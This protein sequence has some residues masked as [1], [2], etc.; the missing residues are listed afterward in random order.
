MPSEGA[1]L[2]RSRQPASGSRPAGSRSQVP[3]SDP[4][5]SDPLPPTRAIPGTV[6]G[7]AS[8]RGRR[9]ALR[10][11]PG[12]IRGGA[13]HLAAGRQRIPET[14]AEDA[15]RRCLAPEIAPSR[16]RQPLSR[17]AIA[18]AWL[19]SLRAGPCDAGY[20][21]RHGLESRQAPRSSA[22]TRRDSRRCQTP[23]CGP[24]APSGDAGR[25]CLPEVPGSEDRAN[26]HPAA[27]Q[28]DRD[29]RCLAPIPASRPVRCWLRCQARPRIAA[30]APV[31]GSNPARFEEVPDTSLRAG[32]AFRRRRPK[33]PGSGDRVKPH[34]AAAQPDRDRRCLAPIPASPPVRCRL[35]CQ[36][37]PRIAAGAP[38]SGSN[39]ARFEEVPDTSLWAGSVFRKC[40]P[41][42]PGSDPSRHAAEPR[43][44]CRSR[45]RP[46]ATP[47]VHAARAPRPC[48][49][50]G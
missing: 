10:Q 50:A 11:Q 22:A 20:G 17:T 24:A 14:P 36:A 27:A 16:I 34:P 42:V 6:S 1:W 15:S 18:G 47:S 8:N 5:C 28:P 49:S 37:R 25:S 23:R 48:P 39:P 41:K 26:P 44:R 29:R 46:R 4:L 2:R 12:A 35:R 40:R 30:G 38:V 19:R 31:S 21:V 13:R 45:P 9:P 3:G 32:S 33:M 7:T 43:L